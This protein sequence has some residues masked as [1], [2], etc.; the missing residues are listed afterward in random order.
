M[1]LSLAA[2]PVNLPVRTTSGPSLA[3][4]PSPRRTACSTSGAVWRFQKISAP[5]A[6]SCASRP[7]FGTRLL[8]RKFPSVSDQNGGGRWAAAAYVCNEAPYKPESAPVKAE[9]PSLYHHG[10][11]IKP[12]LERDQAELESMSQVIALVDDDR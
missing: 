1:N 10:T 7:R 3:S 9:A 11:P 2:R 12:C 8:T 4:R 6:M 5:V